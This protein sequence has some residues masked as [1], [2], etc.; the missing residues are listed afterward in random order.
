MEC[1]D[2]ENES[3]EELDIES[4]VINKVNLRRVYN[5]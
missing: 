1:L 5:S 3:E 4:K 2:K